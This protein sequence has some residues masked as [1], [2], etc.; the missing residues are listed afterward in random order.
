MKRFLWVDESGRG[1][2]AEW[3]EDE[4]RE[5]LAKGEA[6]AFGDYATADAEEAYDE[7]LGEWLD[8][9]DPGNEYNLDAARLVC[10]RD[11]ETAPVWKRQVFTIEERDNGQRLVVLD[12]D[13]RPVAEVRRLDFGDPLHPLTSSTSRA[14]SANRWRLLA[15]RIVR[16]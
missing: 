12:A 3:N 14:A 15:D 7:T 13:A 10:V 6:G 1:F 8:R 11:D 9:C 2:I 4:I 5:E 16:G